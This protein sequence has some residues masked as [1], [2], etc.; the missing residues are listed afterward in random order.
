MSFKQRTRSKLAIIV[1]TSW[2]A[3]LVIMLV[4]GG[5]DNDIDQWVGLMK[6]FSSV[7]SGIVG[8]IVGYYFGKDDKLEETEQGNPADS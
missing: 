3:S 7:T 1:V 6:E 2:I 4:L 5:L 8:A